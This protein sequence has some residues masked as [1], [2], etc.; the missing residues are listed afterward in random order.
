MRVKGYKKRGRYQWQR[1]SKQNNK[2]SVVAVTGLVLPGM[3]MFDRI[4]KIHI[5]QKKV[6]ETTRRRQH[7]DSPEQKKKKSYLRLIPN[8]T[9]M[10]SGGE[11]EYL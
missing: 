4:K 8:Y 10:M 2:T 11:N 1:N 5:I 7:N 3:S 9:V 6:I